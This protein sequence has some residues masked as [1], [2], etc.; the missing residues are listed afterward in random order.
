MDTIGTQTDCTYVS[1]QLEGGGVPGVLH[2]DADDVHG[3]LPTATTA[4]EGKS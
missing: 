2:L 4:E 1:E 3:P